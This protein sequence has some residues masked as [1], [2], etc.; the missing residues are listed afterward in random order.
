DAIKLIRFKLHPNPLVPCL[1]L[2]VARAETELH[3]LD[4][5]LKSGALD[6]LTTQLLQAYEPSHPC[7]IIVSHADAR[8]DMSELK[9]Q[10]LPQSSG[11]ITPCSSLYIPAKPRIAQPQDHDYLK[12]L[13][14][15]EQMYETP[16]DILRRN[17]TPSNKNS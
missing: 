7:K 5:R 1:I 11:L 16:L 15:L 2:Q 3:T 6:K 10:N 13:N 12:S 4:A 17:V 8:A 14:H 9:I